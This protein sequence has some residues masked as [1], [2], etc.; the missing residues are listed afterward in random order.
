MS[1]TLLGFDYGRKRIGVAS[2]EELTGSSTPLDTVTVTVNGPDWPHIERLIRDWRPALL[3]V[4]LP[5]N[6]DG[7]EHAMSAAARVFAEQLGTHSQL[8]VELVDERL[9]S[10][11]AEEMIS[12]QRRGGRIKKGRAKAAI[13]QV[14]ASVIL[15]TWLNG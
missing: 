2:G 8:P 13:D 14:A 10:L 5:M 15:Q 1:R 6:M 9:S 12:E 7:T 4:G 3:I 11:A